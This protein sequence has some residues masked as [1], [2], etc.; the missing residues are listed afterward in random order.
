[1]LFVIQS[2]LLGEKP[3]ELYCADLFAK[4]GVE[5]LHLDFYLVD[6]QFGHL[7]HST[8]CNEFICLIP[9]FFRCSRSSFATIM[10]R[11]ATNSSVVWSDRS[12]ATKEAR[13]TQR[14]QTGL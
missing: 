13:Q 11:K 10:T 8:S 7:K 2:H 14:K 12:E 1:M 6:L 9:A 4:E 3:K 5:T